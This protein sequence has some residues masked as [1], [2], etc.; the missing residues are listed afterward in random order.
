MVVSAERDMGLLECGQEFLLGGDLPKILKIALI[1][2]EISL[3]LRR[4]FSEDVSSI[5]PQAIIEPAL[6]SQKMSS[7]SHGVEK[8][9]VH[10]TV[11]RL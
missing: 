10:Y 6:E 1:F 7:G 11:S 4:E 5:L 2:L 3:Q 8:T 9:L